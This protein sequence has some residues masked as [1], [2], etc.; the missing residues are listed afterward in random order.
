[1]SSFTTKE[2]LIELGQS[3]LFEGKTDSEIAGLMDEINSL[4]YGGGIERYILQGRKLLSSGSSSADSSADDQTIVSVDLPDKKLLVNINN[5]SDASDKDLVQAARLGAEAMKGNVFVMV[6]GGLGE[7]LGYSSIKLGLPVETATNTTYIELY[8]RWAAACGRNP[9]W[10]PSSENKY[11]PTTGRKQNPFLIMTSDDTH[12]LTKQHLEANNYFGYDPSSVFL[13]KQDTVPCLIDSTAKVAV[14]KNG[15]LL[16]KPH[17][18]GDVHQLIYGLKFSS[19]KAQDQQLLIDA[20]VAGP[21]G[22]DPYRSITFMQD[23]NAAATSTAPLSVHY[24]LKN[25]WAMAFTSVPRMPGEAIGIYCSQTMG[26]GHTRC[27]N[28]EYNLFSPIYSKTSGKTTEPLIEGTKYSVFPGSINTL[29]MDLEAYAAALHKDKGHVPE[30]INPKYTDATKTAFKSPARIESLMQDIAF[31][32]DFPRQKIGCTTFNRDT[33]EPVKNA[34]ADGVA[35]AVDKGIAAACAATGEEAW[36]KMNRER[37]IAAGVHIETANAPKTTVVSPADK[38]KSISVSLFPIVTYDSKFI[39]YSIGEAIDRFPN[40]SAVKISARSTLVIKGNVVIKSLVLDGALV[41]DATEFSNGLA[42]NGA[43]PAVI[44]NLNV[45][46]DGWEATPI[47]A[48]EDS[49]TLASLTEV[50][51]IRGYVLT[52]KNTA[53]LTVSADG[54]QNLVTGNPSL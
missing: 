39:N 11:S 22:E 34:L 10:T 28:I 27:G 4:T 33:F 15:K 30:F 37:V 9:S 43:S 49:H 20:L 26:N 7:R 32:F 38:S 45:S 52:R 51:R 50:H 35:G 14:G 36:L 6:A 40:P 53:T 46:N 25:E 8:L 17:G 18:H 31:C 48:I 47:D 1:M 12:E 16:R 5:L 29:V 3:H 54:T 13:M 24:L 19:S 44:E 23:T 2:R 42:G 21:N 41:I